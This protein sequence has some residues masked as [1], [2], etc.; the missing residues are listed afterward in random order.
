MRIQNTVW[1]EGG[2]G[3]CRARLQGCGLWPVRKFCM[4]F[5]VCWETVK[6]VTRSDLCC[7]HVKFSKGVVAAEMERREEILAVFRKNQQGLLR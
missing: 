1:L 4:L 2:E 3:G 6:G 7:I 5:Q